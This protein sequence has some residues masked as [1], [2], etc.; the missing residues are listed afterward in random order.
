MERFSTRQI[1]KTIIMRSAVSI[2]QP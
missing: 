1:N 2:S